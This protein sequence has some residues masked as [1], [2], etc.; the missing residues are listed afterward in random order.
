MLRDYQHGQLT[1][2]VN[3]YQNFP[4]LKNWFHVNFNITPESRP[5]IEQALD[6]TTMAPNYW[7]TDNTTTIS[8]LVKTA[9]LPNYKFEVKTLNQYNKK[10]LNKSSIKY[11][12]VNLEFHD[13]MGSSMRSFWFAYYQYHIQDPSHAWPDKQQL[14]LVWRNYGPNYSSVYDDR[15]T[16]RWGLDTIDQFSGSANFN[17]VSPFFEDIRI[18][19]FARRPN[20]SYG[21]MFHEYVLVNPVITTFQHDTLDHSQGAGTKA[22]MTLEYETVLY[23]QGYISDGDITSWNDVR[24]RYYDNTPSPLGTAQQRFTPEIFSDFVPQPRV[25]LNTVP[26]VP[27]P[28]S[29]ITQVGTVKNAPALSLTQRQELNRSMASNLY[30]IEQGTT[31]ITVPGVAKNS[32]LNLTA[33]NGTIGTELAPSTSLR[34]N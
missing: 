14:P 15:A 10:T 23:H 8:V 3:N 1:F 31:T 16:E 18:Y 20:D 25:N 21:A 29:R 11:D 5:T 26:Q 24:A 34:G 12:P 28:E 13:D 33:N 32:Q 30:Q 2:L 17:R 7:S 27:T 9:S 4:K 19:Q 22:S 6:Q